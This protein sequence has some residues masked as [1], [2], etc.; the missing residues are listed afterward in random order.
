MESEAILNRENLT[1]C[2]FQSDLQSG[3]VSRSKSSCYRSPSDTQWPH[4]CT[5]HS[6]SACT[7]YSAY[8]APSRFYGT[9]TEELKTL[10]IC[11]W[12]DN[13]SETQKLLCRHR[14]GH[15]IFFEIES[16]I[17]QV[18]T[19][20]GKRAAQNPLSFSP[21]A[22]RVQPSADSPTNMRLNIHYM[23][24]QENFTCHKYIIKIIWYDAWGNFNFISGFL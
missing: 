14:W 1:W 10:Q 18:I 21:D 15:K 17:I 24:V 16:S 13:V 11:C 8:K 12:Y 5:D 22:G 2:R 9:D 19:T 23:Q 20:P 3:S 6:W 7:P 4:H